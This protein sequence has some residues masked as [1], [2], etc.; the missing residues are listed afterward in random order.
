VQTGDTIELNYGSARYSAKEE[1]QQRK[2]GSFQE[3]D[4]G[5]PPQIFKYDFA[6]D[7]NWSYNAWIKDYLPH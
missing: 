1:Y 3:N 6:F 7:P 5:P 2:E 4:V